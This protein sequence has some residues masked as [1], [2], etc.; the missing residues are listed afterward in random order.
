MER[1]WSILAVRNGRDW[2]IRL[3][4]AA[5]IVL[6]SGAE[7]APST[8]SKDKRWRHALLHQVMV[9]RDRLARQHRLLVNDR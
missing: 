4:V 2:E 9:P 3:H 6:Q 8:V 1:A 7:R 5:F